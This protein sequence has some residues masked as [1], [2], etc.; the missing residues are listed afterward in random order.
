[1]QVQPKQPSVK[2]PAERFT[3]DAW[4]DVIASGESPS[5]VRVNI[6]RFAPGARNACTLM[7]SGRPYTSPRAWG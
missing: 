4:F 6:V 5:R 1:M 7:R 3:G 2:G